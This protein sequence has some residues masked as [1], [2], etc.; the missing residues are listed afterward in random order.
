L[1]A[2]DAEAG[3]FMES[4]VEDATVTASILGDDRSMVGQ[5]VGAYQL[6]EKIGQGGM[7]AVDIKPANILV[8]TGGGLKLLDFGIAKVLNERL[9]PSSAEQTVLAPAPMTPE[10]ASPEQV[11]GGHITTA[12][13]I[14]SLGVVLY[15]LLTGRGLYPTNLEARGAVADSQSRIATVLL[16][17][18]D[19]SKA[20][21]VSETA[22]ATRQAIAAQRSGALAP[23]DR[24]APEKLCH[25]IA[26][27]DA[28]PVGRSE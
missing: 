1:L 21:A 18:G 24:M 28:A 27:C 2:N 9:L 17:T 6:L 15:K 16:K 5:R 20:L 22:L 12:T 19:V 13:G 23:L 7:G 8:T 25:A 4:P 10:Y 11:R 3:D 26:R 14:Y